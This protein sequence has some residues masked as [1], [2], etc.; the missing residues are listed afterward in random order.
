MK[1]IISRWSGTRQG[2]LYVLAALGYE[3]SHIEP[4]YEQDPEHWAEFIIFLK[5]SKQ[6][7]VNNL[8]VIDAEVRKVKEGSSRPFYGTESMTS[9]A[10]A[11]LASSLTRRIAVFRSSNS[12]P[13]TRKKIANWLTARRPFFSG[14]N[15]RS[16]I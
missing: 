15:R 6:S 16:N 3:Q 8:A 10:L 4:V 9:D 13:T 5:G 14:A 11:T 7:G 1:G 2:I 12:R